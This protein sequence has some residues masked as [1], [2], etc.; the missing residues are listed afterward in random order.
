MRRVVDREQVRDRDVG[1]ALR[2]RERRVAEHLLDRAEIR[3]AVEQVRR[4]GVAERVRMEI[5]AA[6]AGEAVAADEELRGA[7]VEAAPARRDED[8]LRIEEA[9]PRMSE[10]GGAASH[11]RSASSALRPRGRCAP[12]FPCR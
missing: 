6:G 7:R 8:R 12:S 2:R 10:R 5:G 3:A 4:A 11:A 9:R 1:V